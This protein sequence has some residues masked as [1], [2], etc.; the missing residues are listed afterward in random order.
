MT[1]SAPLPLREVFN[2]RDLGGLP[3]RTG[4]V[5][6]GGAVY[7]ADGLQRL[8]ADDRDLLDTL[9]LRT[10]VDLR[11]ERELS[12]WGGAPAD[13]HE[14]QFH[15]LPVITTTWQMESFDEAAG[16]AQF[17]RDRYLE[18][19][20]EGAAAIVTVLELIADA[21]R[22]ALVFHCAAGKDRTG[23][24]AAFL[25][26]LLG[27]DDATIAADYA[28]SG[29]AMEQMEAWYRAR[30]PERVEAMTTQPAAFRSCPPEAMLL[31]LD[32]VRTRWGSVDGCLAAAGHAPTT[33]QALRDQ[34]LV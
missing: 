8:V 33:T 26:S 3:T 22:R 27:V 32:H 21:D 5:V 11:T 16:P 18:M 34:L 4:S 9:E 2:F 12:E 10:I 25:L 14:A 23:V 30:Y 1:V 17:L 15:H 28:R 19:I 24:V 31:F 29:L 6:R 13:L 20:D 7:R